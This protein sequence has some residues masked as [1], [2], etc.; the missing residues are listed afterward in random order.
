LVVTSYQLL[1]ATAIA[2]PFAIVSHVVGRVGVPA[3]DLS[4]WVAA[5]AAGLAGV[6]LPFLLY[7]RA[8]VE[9]RATIAA[10]VLNLVPLVGFVTAIVFLGDRPTLPAFAGGGLILLSAAWLGRSEIRA[11]VP[12]LSSSGAGSFHRCAAISPTRD[13]Q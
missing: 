12:P 4:H 5:V 1:A 11:D 2:V 6:A 13:E 7:N 3:A 8:I 10:G 9:V